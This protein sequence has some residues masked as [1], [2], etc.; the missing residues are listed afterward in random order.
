MGANK[1]FRGITEVSS[2]V[3]LVAG[4]LSFTSTAVCECLTVLP[5]VVY[6]IEIQI[7][8]ELNIVSY[9]KQAEHILRI[10]EIHN[11]LFHVCTSS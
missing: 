11:R 8:L 7:L 1:T 6:G 2:F 3:I 5:V 9:F 10:T 4:G